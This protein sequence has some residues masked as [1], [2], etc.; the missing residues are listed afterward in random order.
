M[1]RSVLAI[2]VLLAA[3]GGVV[4]AQETGTP[5]FKAPYRAFNAHEFG[6]NLSFPEG[7]DFGLEGF[8]TYG[9]NRFDIGLR[10]GIVSFDTP[11][12]DDETSVVLGASFRARVVEA[13]QSFPLDGALTLGAGAIFGEGDDVVL[14]PLGISLGRRLQL[15]GSRVSFVPYVHP[16]LVPRLGGGDDEVDFALGLGVDVRFSEALDLRVSAGIGEVEGVAL[17]LAFVR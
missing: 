10:G 12:G 15:E 1:H 5:V 9:Y 14:I 2:L 6:A 7:A 4:S 3:G 13:T 8:Y 16:V 11:L 17:G